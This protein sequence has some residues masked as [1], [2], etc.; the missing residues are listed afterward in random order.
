MNTVRVEAGYL[1]GLAAADVQWQTLPFEQDG[2]RVDVA[3]PVLTALQMQAIAERV[4]RAS[5]QHLK[6]MTVSEIIAVIDRAIARLLDPNDPYR[7]QADAL[8]PIVSG[9]DVEMVRLGLT[10][11]FKTFRA[12]QLHRFVAEDFANPKVLDGFQPAAKGGAVRAYGPQL[13]AHSWAGNVPALALWSLVCGLLVKA[14]NI[15]KLP[16]AEPLFAGWFARLLAEVHPPLADCLAVVWWRGAGDEDASALYAQADTVVA[17][18]GNDALHAIQRRLPV[19]ARFLAHGHKLGFGVVSAMALDAQK[20]PALAR[21]AA[22]DVM[23]YDQQGCYSPHVFYVQRGGPVSP[24]DFAGYLAGE[25]SNLQRRFP[26]RALDLE[27]SAAA[28]KWR[29]SIEW[30]LTPDG[31]DALIGDMETAWSVAYIDEAASLAPTALQRSITVA[32]IDALD[33]VAPLVACRR[34]FL[35]TAGV[36]ATPE[37]LYRLA[38][39]LGTAGVT[40]VSAI[41]AMSVPEAGWHHDGRFNLLDLVRMTEIEQSAEAAADPFASYEP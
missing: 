41:G 20:A 22:W 37:E 3:V 12:P 11:F 26:R 28:A 32:G 15:G 34:E 30:T 7:R 6:T 23:R 27:E 1:P 38:E 10:G 13:L 18:G 35:Q 25:L 31:A 16:S 36:A 8:L 40:R 9:Y 17:Y 33:E 21:R 2:Q 39:Q 14:G 29:Q 5:A 4:K 19:T 24:R